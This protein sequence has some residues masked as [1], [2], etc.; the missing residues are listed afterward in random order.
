M[1]IRRASCWVLS[2]VVLLLPACAGQNNESPKLVLYN[3]IEEKFTKKPDDLASKAEKEKYDK[4][5]IH[6][7]SEFASMKVETPRDKE[8]E[9]VKNFDKN[10]KGKFTGLAY[11]SMADAIEKIRKRLTE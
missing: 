4:E 11:N 7:I 6:M 9:I 2:S 8:K 5:L 1:S 10:M 3:A